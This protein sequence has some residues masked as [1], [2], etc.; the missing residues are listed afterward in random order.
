MDATLHYSLPPFYLVQSLLLLPACSRRQSR[1][2]SNNHR[3]EEEKR[4][5]RGNTTTTDLNTYCIDVYTSKGKK[6]FSTL[7][8]C[9]LHFGLLCCPFLVSRSRA[10]SCPFM[11][12]DGWPV[13]KFLLLIEGPARSPSS[14]SRMFI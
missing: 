8:G 2:L 3:E 13:L 6:G 12:D 10:A 4:R 11:S 5:E 9:C 7:I 1:N 14:L